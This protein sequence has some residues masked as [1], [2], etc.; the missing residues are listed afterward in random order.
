MGWSCHLA[1]RRHAHL[2]RPY[3]AVT[4]RQA[5][6]HKTEHAPVWSPYSLH[7]LHKPCSPRAFNNKGLFDEHRVSREQYAWGG[8]GGGGGGVKPGMHCC[9]TLQR[10]KVLLWTVA[11][12]AFHGL[13][14]PEWVNDYAIPA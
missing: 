13:P 2:Q 6:T 12:N 14:P 3:V 11:N 9:L 4:V 5:T 10:P 8:G 7:P 1:T